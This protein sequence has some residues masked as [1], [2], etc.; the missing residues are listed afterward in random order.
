MHSTGN[1]VFDY[2]AALVEHRDLIR[3]VRIL[4]QHANLVSCC[5]DFV[6]PSQYDRIDAACR[7]DQVSQMIFHYYRKDMLLHYFTRACGLG[8]ND[9]KIVDC[10]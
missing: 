9:Q 6:I 1:D 5:G 4:L 8:H 7:Q 3:R 10:L 2:L